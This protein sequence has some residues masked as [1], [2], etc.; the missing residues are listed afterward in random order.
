MEDLEL[1]LFDL[2]TVN[3]ATNNFCLINRIGIDGFGPVYKVK[4]YYTVDLKVYGV[5]MHQANCM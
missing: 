3:T 1:P 2:A 4:F 5:V